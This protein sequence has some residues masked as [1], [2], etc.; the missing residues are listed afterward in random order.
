M[1]TSRILLDNNVPVHLIPSIR[2]LEAVHASTLGGATL[3]SGQLI[4]AAQE[5]GFSVMIRCDQSIEH[6]QNLSEQPLT[7][8]VLLTTHWPTIRDKI[9]AVLHAIE[10]ATPGSYVTVTFPKPP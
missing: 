7:F 4:R 5:A 10:T 9:A 6:Q 1:P 3:S 8:V 2:P